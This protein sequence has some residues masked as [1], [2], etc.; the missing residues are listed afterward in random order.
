M[1]KS[2][3]FFFSMAEDFTWKHDEEE[4]DDGHD[5]VDGDDPSQE[6]EVGGHHGPEVGLDPLDFPLPRDHVGQPLQEPSIG[7]T[8]EIESV[9]NTVADQV[10]IRYL[11]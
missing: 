1:L 3:Y 2:L 9:R 8:E 4:D 11:T 5:E 6:Q 7:G 10:R